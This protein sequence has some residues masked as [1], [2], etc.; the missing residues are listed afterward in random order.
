VSRIA[1]SHVRFGS[2]EIFHYTNREQQVKQLADHVISNHLS[3]LKTLENPYVGLLQYAVTSTA[4]MIAQWQTVGFCHGVMNTDNMSILGITIDY[5]PFAFLDDY[6]PKFICNHSDTNGR[7]AFDQQPGIGLWNLNALAHALSSLL[8]KD[9]IVA[10]LALYEQELVTTFSAI[11]RSK[12]G[13]TS[14]QDN[15]QTLISGLF[16]LMASNQSDYTNTFRSL[17]TFVQDSNNESLRN[18][19]VDRQAFDTWAQQYSVRLAMENSTDAIRSKAMNKV[20]PKFILRNYLAQNAIDAANR[21]DFSEV[22]NLL[23]V[24]S[25]PFDEHSEYEHFANSP[26][27]WGKTLEISCSS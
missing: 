19:F 16:D 18:N 22:Q 12:L 1:P 11:M 17:A 26:P 25:S 10:S 3:E 7:Y 5:G 24:L 23:A 14:E 15:D 8:S 21:K 20:N 4:N 6:Q 27:D 13:L 2:F 9:E